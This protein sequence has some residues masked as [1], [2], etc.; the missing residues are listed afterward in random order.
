VSKPRIYNRNKNNPFPFLY[1]WVYDNGQKECVFMTHAEAIEAAAV[2]EVLDGY[3]EIAEK[4]ER[5]QVD[6]KDDDYGET[7]IEAPVDSLAKANIV[8]SKVRGSEDRHILALDID[9]P[10]MLIPSSTEGHFHLYVDKEMS[11]PQLEL[12]LETLAYAGVIE[13][14]YAKASISRRHT[15]LRTPWTSKEE[16]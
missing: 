9:F 5:H 8:S 14:G 15:S 4:L 11:W 16:K 7:R 12:V 13:G 3:A 2:A 1:P 6:F 10:A